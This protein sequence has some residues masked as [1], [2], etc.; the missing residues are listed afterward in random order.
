MSRFVEMLK[1]LDHGQVIQ[2]LDE[3]LAEV[4]EAVGDYG[5][6][7]DGELVIK[8]TIRRTKQ[9]VA[10]V[11]AKV[12]NKCPREPLNA[13]KLWFD[14]TTLRRDDPLQQ[15]LPGVRT[16]PRQRVRGEEGDDA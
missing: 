11:S 12:T 15:E 13:T 7:G 2:Q 3:D 4:V 9:R 1:E 14:G 16:L 8:L 10:E 5:E 6:H